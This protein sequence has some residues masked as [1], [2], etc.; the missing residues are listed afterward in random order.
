MRRQIEGYGGLY[1]VDT[2]GRIY[3]RM[4]K[5]MRPYDNGYGYLIIDLHTQDGRRKHERVHR[6]VAK[7]FLPNPDNLPEVNHK[8]ENTHNN[9]LLNLE[10]CTSSYN[11][12]Y[13]TGPQR[14]SNAMKRVWTKRRIT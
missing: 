6:L 8:D 11:K 13:G 2:S 12:R 10:W 14:R 7:A 5:L 3:D 1:S 9:T 4:G